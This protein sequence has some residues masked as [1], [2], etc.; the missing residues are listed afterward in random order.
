MVRELKQQEILD[1]L[2][3]YAG[4]WAAVREGR[5]VASSYS[6]KRLLKNKRVLSTDTL[7]AVQQPGLKLY[8]VSNAA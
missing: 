4:Q 6:L 1:D 7:V 3:P 5:F 2:S 8:A